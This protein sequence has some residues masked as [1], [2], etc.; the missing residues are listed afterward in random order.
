MVDLDRT[1]LLIAKSEDVLREVRS[2][3]VELK[4]A[5]D[6]LHVGTG[7]TAGEALE[8]MR[9]VALSRVARKLPVEWVDDGTR[10]YAHWMGSAENGQWRHMSYFHSTHESHPGEDTIVRGIEC[11]TMIAD[12]EGTP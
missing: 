7:M 3:L 2:A 4:S 10:Y 11:A 6:A 12:S 9:K 1:E 5:R 8:V